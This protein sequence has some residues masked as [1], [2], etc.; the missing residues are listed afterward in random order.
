MDAA[1]GKGVQVAGQGGDEGLAFAGLHLGDLAR[2]E[3]DA[4]D[5]LDVEVAH[6]DGALSGFAD[7]GEGFGEDSVEGGLFGGIALVGVFRG[8]G[9]VGDGVGDALT[10]LGGLVAELLVGEGLDGRL[11][12]VNLR[13]DGLNALDSALVAGA[14]DFCN[15]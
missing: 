14:K 4:T 15:D 11:E 9:D 7:D 1:T 6:A 3:D 12:S 13:N 10:E 8:V 5:E 2:V